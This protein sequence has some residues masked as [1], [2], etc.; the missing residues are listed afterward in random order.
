MPSIPGLDLNTSNAIISFGASRIINAV[1]DEHWGIFGQNGLPLLLVDSVVDVSYTNQ[2]TV[3]SVPLEMG[4]YTSINKVDSPYDV[5]ISVIK[6]TGGVTARSAFLSQLEALA[7]SANLFTVITPEAVYT[8]MAIVGY[9]Y[10]RS[11]GDGARAIKASIALK[12]IRLISTPILMADG[13]VVKQPNLLDTVKQ[14][15]SRAADRA[16]QTYDRVLQRIRI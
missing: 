3:A 9:S 7:G 14:S 12:E 15:I 13:K 11:A 16:K 4:S 2:S 8:N 5:Q 1:F 6:T 10:S